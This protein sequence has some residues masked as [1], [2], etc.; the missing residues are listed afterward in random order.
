MKTLAI[1]LAVTVISGVEIASAGNISIEMRTMVSPTV[2]GIPQKIPT[3]A[4]VRGSLAAT[5]VNGVNI[6]VRSSK[7]IEYYTGV[8]VITVTNADRS[9]S[10]VPWVAVPTG[11]EMRDEGMS[12][13]CTPTVWSNGVV[14]MTISGGLH[15][16]RQWTTN[17]CPVLVD[18]RVVTNVALLQPVWD[19]CL[20]STTVDTK[21]GEDVIIGGGCPV[22]D[23]TGYY[24]FVLRVENEAG[25]TSASTVPDSR[26][27]PV[28]DAPGPPREPVR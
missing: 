23:G 7:T 11:S 21:N 10:S 6:T 25:R 17:V 8:D 19:E 20:V 24:Y 12:F 2:I 16:V 28:A 5:T 14:I 26:V 4:I 27:T 3:N 13:S 18:G 15:Y 1:A 22:P 9:G